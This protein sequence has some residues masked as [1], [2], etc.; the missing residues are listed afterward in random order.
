MTLLFAGRSTFDLGYACPEF[1]QENAKFS[2]THFWA[3]AGGCA[4]NAAVAARALGSEVRLLTLLGAGPFAAAVREELAQYD[5]ATDDF[6]D[7]AAEVLPVSSI[8]VVPTNGSRT[9]VDQQPSQKLSRLFDPAVLLEGVCMVL[10]D[11]FLP[12]LAVPLC[13]AARERGIPV[14][15]D[16][17]SWKPWSAEIMPHVDIAV[18]SERFR[19]GGMDHADVI[20]AL[21]RLGPSIVAIS[22]GEGP[23]SWSDGT[24]CGEIEPPQVEAIDTLGAGDILHGALCHFLAQGADFSA[25]LALA[26]GVAAESC[27]YYGTRG[28]IGRAEGA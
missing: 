27:A 1:P 11:G 3:G 9:I 2:A 18:V 24:L 15:L 14:V 25:A 5:V 20:A 26:C 28:W 10:T 21:H 6:A 7:P 13:R 23:L 4:L 12:E 22:R 16:G 17:G 8:V 19:P